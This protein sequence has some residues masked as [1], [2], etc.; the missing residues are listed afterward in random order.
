MGDMLGSRRSQA[1]V[2]AVRTVAR[3]IS[4]PW[5]RQRFPMASRMRQTTGNKL[6]ESMT[7]LFVQVLREKG[8]HAK[9]A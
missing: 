4:F 7:E 5:Q 1:N 9:R 6:G 2:V 3:A 8:E